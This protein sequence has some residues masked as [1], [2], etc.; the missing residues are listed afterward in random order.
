MAFTNP[1]T[2]VAS[3]LV[4]AALLNQQVRDNLSALWVG[5]SAGD[6]DYYTGSNSKS[7]LAK[8]SARAQ[9]RMN[10]AGTAPEW[11]NAIQARVISTAVQTITKDTYTDLTF[12]IELEDTN[13]FWVVGSPTIFTIP[14]TGVYMYGCRVIYNTNSTGIRITTISATSGGSPTDARNSVVGS[15]TNVT[16]NAVGRLSA[17]STIKVIVWQNSGGDL[18][19]S[20]N[21]AYM[22]ATFLGN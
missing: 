2:W 3:Q 17:G 22:W 16:L 15:S 5:T 8:G 19:T 11:G 6:T 9:Y 10:A 18:D 7:R 4:T 21:S 1:L 20:A 12:D 14:Y 13:S